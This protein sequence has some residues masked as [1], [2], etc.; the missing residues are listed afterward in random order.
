[1]LEDT[2][3]KDLLTHE[4]SMGGTVKNCILNHRRIIN[5]HGENMSFRFDEAVEVL[6][7]QI[8]DDGDADLV[9]IDNLFNK[10]FKIF[11][12]YTGDHR[13]FE[14]MTCNDLSGCLIKNWNQDP[15]KE[16]MNKLLK[17][18]VEIKMMHLC[19][20]GRKIRNSMWRGPR[21]VRL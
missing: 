16:Q 3:P 1:M 11:G 20:V 12:C 14:H 8:L 21:S 9:Q 2:S 4:T 10:D 19:A 7:H 17:E 5:C 6:Q 15:I 18:H 13:D